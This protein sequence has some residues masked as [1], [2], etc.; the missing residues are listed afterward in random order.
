MAGEKKTSFYI[1]IF[2]FFLPPHFFPTKFSGFV[3]DSTPDS[4]IEVTLVDHE[5][6]IK[7]YSEGDPRVKVGRRGREG[8]V[9]RG[10]NR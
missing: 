10:I 6:N 4:I 8:E 3:G 2:H 5:G 9:E 7:H 1:H